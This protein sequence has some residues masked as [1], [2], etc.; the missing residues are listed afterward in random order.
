VGEVESEDRVLVLKRIHVTYTLKLGN[1]HRE[2]AERVHGWHAEKCPIARSIE[3]AIR[4]TTELR[5]EP[6][7]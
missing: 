2:I 1:E 7:S 5:L 6:L 4:V 3:R